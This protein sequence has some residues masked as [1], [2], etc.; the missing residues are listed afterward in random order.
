AECKEAFKM[1]DKDRSGAISRTELAD[2]MRILG[3]NPTDTEIN[4]LMSELDKNE[5]GLIEFDEFL[6]LMSAHLKDP[7]DEARE[8]RDAFQIF[9]RDGN[10]FI[11]A[12]EIR[13]VM[14]NI[15]EKLTD[16]QIDKIFN[17]ADVNQ[18]GKLDYDGMH[19]APSPIR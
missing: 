1:F 2:V 16:E 8:L 18:D 7:E 3:N 19:S 6:V 13:F 9:D 15:G 12:E 14:K 10:N 17:M 4:N 11:D 5:N